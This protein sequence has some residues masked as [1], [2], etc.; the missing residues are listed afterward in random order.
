MNIFFLYSI[1]II[2]IVVRQTKI[3]NLITNHLNK[4]FYFISFTD[5]EYFHH[6]EN[7]F[8]TL[9]S[10]IIKSIL[11]SPKES[12]ITKSTIGH[13]E[14]VAP[15]DTLCPDSHHISMGHQVSSLTPCDTLRNVKLMFYSGFFGAK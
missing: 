7:F 4:L 15:R 14:C 3:E 5:W 13:K 9:E 10:S 6:L 11:S 12:L 2:Q 1:I 8:N